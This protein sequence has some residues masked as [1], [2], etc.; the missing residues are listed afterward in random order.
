MNIAL[1][2]EQ[3]EKFEK[4][5]ELLTEWNKKINLTSITEKREVEVKHF[6]DSLTLIKTGCFAKA[7]NTLDVGA[8]AGFP[9][10]PLAIVLPNI[11]FTLIDSQNKRIKFI[12]VVKEELNLKNVEAIHERAENAGYLKEKFDIVVARAVAP[13]NVLCELCLPY[14]NIG[15]HFLA[16]KGNNA[17]EVNSAQNAVKI[18]GGDFENIIDAGLDEYE[19]KI[20]I[21]KK[22]QK[23]PVK[24]PRKAGIPS[25]NPLL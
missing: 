10:V 8:G 11:N 4:Y 12:N 18:L 2:T 19:H 1:S 5:F 7:R 22:T 21:I 13:L 20:I 3:T 23:T 24:Y 16:Q 15:G 9:S 25:K 6:L 14:T 17:D